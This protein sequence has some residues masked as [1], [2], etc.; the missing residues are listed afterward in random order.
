MLWQCY[1]DDGFQIPTVSAYFSSTIVM[2]M[3]RIV[4]SIILLQRKVDL[5]TTVGCCT[6][7]AV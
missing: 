2:F 6:N 1:T 4:G 7:A 5:L 3:S